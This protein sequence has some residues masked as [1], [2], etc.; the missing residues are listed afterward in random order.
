MGVEVI[1]YLWR[2][3]RHS[4]VAAAVGMVTG[5]LPKPLAPVVLASVTS[6]IHRIRSIF[7]GMSE[8]VEIY[9]HASSC[10]PF[11]PSVLYPRVEPLIA[12]PAHV[13]DSA[14]N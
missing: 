11:S 5:S 6:D 14:K 13:C 8:A 3:R 12:R 2:Y 1:G 4:D 9:N 10:S 7:T